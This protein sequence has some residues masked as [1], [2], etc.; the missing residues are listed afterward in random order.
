MDSSALPFDAL[1][2]SRG[3]EPMRRSCGRHFRAFT[4]HITCVS[5][6]TPLRSSAGLVQASEKDSRVVRRLEVVWC[7]SHR[8]L[9]GALEIRRG[10]VKQVS[11]I[12]ENIT[13]GHNAAPGSHC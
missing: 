13:W 8:G 11:D 9:G 5:A 12:D 2:K 3:C 10:R 7:S 4:A 1:V 6:G